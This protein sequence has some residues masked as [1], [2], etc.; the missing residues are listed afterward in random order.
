MY[1]RYEALMAGLE[2]LPEMQEYL[3][4]LKATADARTQ[5]ALRAPAEKSGYKTKLL[6]PDDIS[7]RDV[8]KNNY[9][10]K[11][12]FDRG[13]D[14]VMFGEWNAGKTFVALDM[15]ACVALGQPWFGHRVRKA[16]VLYLGYEGHAGLKRRV[17]TLT[18]K[19]PGLANA[20]FAWWPMVQPIADE[21]GQKEL[22]VALRDYAVRFVH[23]PEL[24]FVDTMR[25]ALGGS[26]SDPEKVE[27]LGAA[28]RTATA[29]IERAGA[30][31]TMVKLHHTGHGHKD[32]ARGDSGIVAGVDSEIR[33][34]A[35]ENGQP[36][37]ILTTKERDAGKSE[38]YF[39]LHVVELGQDDDGDMVT[40]CTI[41]PAVAPE[42]TLEAP[43]ASVEEQFREAETA[44]LRLLAREIKAG[45]EHSIRSLK[46]LAPSHGIGQRLAEI[47]IDRLEGS[48][49]IANEPTGRKKGR[50][51]RLAIVGD[52]PEE[53]A[54]G[55]F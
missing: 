44:V 31:C 13:S 9:L 16:R 23:M 46:R 49:R 15:A 39:R 20:P 24:I 40:T 38:V 29:G 14:V 18:G 17:K 6:T 25:K 35:G 41:E 8:L 1:N 37:K 48:G 3:E 10:I 54:V 45:R 51:E 28:L 26:D 27:L 50:R 4:E 30:P 36:G 11:H 43:G 21:K 53:G 32:R 34:E 33:V 7:M 12:W 52:W 5:E 22:L 19:Y 42:P 55:H 47:A 2:G